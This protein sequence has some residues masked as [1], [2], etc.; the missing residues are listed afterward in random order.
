MGD[1]ETAQKV[2]ELLDAGGEPDGTD[3][4][5]AL[6]W[7]RQ[8]RVHLLLHARFGGDADATFVSIRAAASGS[9]RERIADV[10]GRRTGRRMRRFSWGRAIPPLAAAALLL[11]AVL[12]GRSLL[13]TPTTA[14]PVIAT[15]PQMVLDHLGPDLVIERGGRRV[16]PDAGMVLQDGDLLATGAAKAGVRFS[17]GTQVGLAAGSRVAFAQQAGKTLDLQA[18]RLDG[19]VAKQPA[20]Q[21][22][23]IQTPGSRIEVVGT[24]FTVGMEP[25]GTR[26][27]VTEG[28]VRLADQHGARAV[29]V[30]VGQQALGSWFHAPRLVAPFDP[31]RLTT[32]LR[33]RAEDPAAWTATM[34]GP[35]SADAQQEP[36]G[37]AYVRLAITA[38]ARDGWGSRGIPVRLAPGDQAFALR[39]RVRSATPGN[40]IA[41]DMADDVGNTWR[42]GEMPMAAGAGWQTHQVVLPPAS[43]PPP[44][45][46]NGSDPDFRLSRLRLLWVYIR[47]AAEVDLADLVVLSGPD[48]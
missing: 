24:R 15:T 3:A 26:L 9:R 2:D 6:A 45:T 46:T 33:L 37:P 23:R 4:D 36:G 16:M 38:G 11:V 1:L 17:D 12:V 32:R 43:D 5:L 22:L 30:N 34:Y 42:L 14:T 25:A 21:P 7:E 29:A 27:T 47:G 41:F 10:I 31:T 44:R 40:V 19:D 8:R 48:P 35:I 13:S 28:S 39:L 20:G 18:G